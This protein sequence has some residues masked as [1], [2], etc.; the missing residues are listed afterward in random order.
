[1]IHIF[2]TKLKID[3]LSLP[4][5]LSDY[6]TNE[7]L[8]FDRHKFVQIH[9]A[10][11][12]KNLNFGKFESKD[13][14]KKCD[15]V[16][17]IHDDLTISS[18]DIEYNNNSWFGKN[19]L[20]KKDILNVLVSHDECAIYFHRNGIDRHRLFAEWIKDELLKKVTFHYKIDHEDLFSHTEGKPFHLLINI[21]LDFDTKDEF[22][23]ELI[24]LKNKTFGTNEEKEQK[25]LLNKKLTFLHNLLGGYLDENLKNELEEEEFDIEYKSEAHIESIKVI[26]D[27]L[28]EII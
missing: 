4:S 3:N 25:A 19:S 2:F 16:I 5:L 11:N 24:A 18:D 7:D 17:L 23:K 1:M 27:N 26:R 28:L 8:S 22:E 9:Y 10:N 12:T 21:L 20:I 14:T 15:S 13:L 6:L